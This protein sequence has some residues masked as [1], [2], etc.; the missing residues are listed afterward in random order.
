V[1]VFRARLDEKPDLSE[2]VHREL[3]ADPNLAVPLVPT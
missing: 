3:T 1:A 2:L